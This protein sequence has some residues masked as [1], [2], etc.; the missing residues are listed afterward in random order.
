MTTFKP[1][2]NPPHVTIAAFTFLGSKKICF[3]GPAANHD[4][5]SSF[6]YFP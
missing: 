5:V 2:H 3:L 6:D 4:F 1:G